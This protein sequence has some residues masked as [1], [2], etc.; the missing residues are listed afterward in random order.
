MASEQSRRRER[1]FEEFDGGLGRRGSVK[2]VGGER[3][4]RVKELGL[5]SV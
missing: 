4:E 2:V 5:I 3:C 1:G